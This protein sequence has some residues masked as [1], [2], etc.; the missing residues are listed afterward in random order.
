MTPLVRT[1]LDSPSRLFSVSVRGLCSRS[2]VE[3]S[4]R[5]LW[6]MSLFE[7]S[8]CLK[9]LLKV[10]VRSACKIPCKF[11]VGSALC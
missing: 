3:V 1:K 8:F 2:L 6:S 7:V 5:G 9:S 10:S 11:G 4:A